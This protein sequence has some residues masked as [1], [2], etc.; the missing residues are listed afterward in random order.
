MQEKTILGKENQ[1]AA[2]HRAA[3]DCQLLVI[4]NPALHMLQQQY[5]YA[6]RSTDVY[7]QPRITPN[8]DGGHGYI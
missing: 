3:G 1:R 4:D 6:I 8:T 2:P 5:L 7:L